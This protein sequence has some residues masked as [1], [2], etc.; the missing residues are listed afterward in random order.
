MKP[1]LSPRIVLKF[2][3]TKEI[4]FSTILLIPEYV[5]FFSKN[6][7]ESVPTMESVDIIYKLLNNMAFPFFHQNMAL[8][9]NSVFLIIRIHLNEMIKWV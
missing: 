1:A 9:D 7:Y 4:C 5:H 6:K 2:L 8:R 3:S